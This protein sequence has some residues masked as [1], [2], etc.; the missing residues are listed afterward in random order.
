[1]CSR[2]WKAAGRLVLT[3]LPLTPLAFADAPTPVAVCLWLAVAFYGG[4][5]AWPSG[6]TLI[7]LLEVGV[8]VTLG[9]LA[10]VTPAP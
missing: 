6:G 4:L 1:M 3:I 8:A 7:K 9:S 5:L 2:V 10:L